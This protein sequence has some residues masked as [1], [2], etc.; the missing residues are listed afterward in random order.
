MS[1]QTVSVSLCTLQKKANNDAYKMTHNCNKLFF[2][3]CRCCYCF[4][5]IPF[6]RK[7]MV[8][9][10][11]TRPTQKKNLTK[12]KNKQKTPKYLPNIHV[13]RKFIEKIRSGNEASKH[14][15]RNFFFKCFVFNWWQLTNYKSSAHWLSWE[16][17]VIWTI[18]K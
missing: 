16:R 2:C 8:C 7:A 6:M 5:L 3:C 11:A 12:N 17:N 14:I 9:P 13:Y 15:I 18:I 1:V 10:V 4:K